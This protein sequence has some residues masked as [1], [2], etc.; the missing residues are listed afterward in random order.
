MRYD[1]NLL[2]IFVALMQERSVTRAAER[3]G[4][5][6]PALSNAL[7]RSAD[8]LPGSTLHPRTL[9]HPA[10]PG[11][12]RTRARHCRG[13]GEAQRRGARSTGVRFFHS[14]AAADRRVQRVCRTRSGS[15]PRREG[16]GSRARHHAAP[17]PVYSNDLADRQASSPASP[18]WCLAGSSIRRTAWSCSTS[19]MRGSPAWCGRAIPKISSTITRDQFERLRHVN[20]VTP[21]R[22]RAG[23]VSGAG[24]ATDSSAML[25]SRSPISSLSPRW[26]PSPITARRCPAWSVA[27][28]P[29]DPRL[30]V[31]SPPVD[32]GTFPVEMA[33]HV[34]YRPRSCT[35]L[36][37][38]QYRRS[39]IRIGWL[40]ISAA[41]IIFK[42]NG[43]SANTSS[44]SCP[45]RSWPGADWRRRSYPR[46]KADT[47]PTR[48][49]SALIGIHTSRSSF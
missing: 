23:T 39:G 42:A 15:R 5:T 8:H 30:K 25:R 19:S 11:C 34:R 47:H 17:D 29:H 49:V 6:Q 21:G 20:V 41:P 4:M 28:W 2:P 37:Q 10:N 48:F 40:N 44:R 45:G 14:R 38:V 13:A 3:L 24:A 27:G 7:S 1:L 46:R 12:R 16:S 9:R 31:L 43:T 33:W 36:A 26:S 22:M 35:P 32:L 18:H